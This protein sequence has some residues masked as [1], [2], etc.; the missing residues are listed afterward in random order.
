L[1]ERQTFLEELMAAG[2][3]VIALIMGNRQAPSFFDATQ[4]GLVTSFIALLLAVALRAFVPILVSPA[5]D[6]ALSSVAQYAILFVAQ[7]GFTV[8]A[9]S[10]MKRM[11]ALVPYLIADNWVTFFLTLILAAFAAAGVGGDDATADGIMIVFAIILIIIEVN[12]GRLVMGLSPLQIAMLIVAQIVGLL[13]AVA[14]I[15][16]L[17]PTSTDA[18]AAT[19]MSSLM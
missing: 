16:T 15:S 12:I 6:S 11:D 3:G 10:Q 5:H 4:R 7:L 2:R 17:F 1:A 19:Q 8:I 18:A 13:I 9:L 14:V